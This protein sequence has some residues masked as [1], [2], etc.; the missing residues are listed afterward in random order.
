MEQVHGCIPETLAMSAVTG[1]AAP[2]T[3]GF[4][5]STVLEV[6]KMPGVSCLG[7][8]CANRVARLVSS[9]AILLLLTLT[10][11]QPLLQYMACR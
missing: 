7:G 2:G 1:S 10:K 5:S 4:Q 3:F 9:R 6:E 11:M 8:C